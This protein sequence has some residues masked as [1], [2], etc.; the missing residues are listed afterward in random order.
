M[1]IKNKQL[2]S[3][4]DFCK[5]KYNVQ[6][7]NEQTNS[8]LTDQILK[9][10]NCTNCYYG[11]PGDGIYNHVQDYICVNNESEYVTQFVFQNMY[12]QFWIER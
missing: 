7:I 5:N 2:I 3:F 11:Q 8:K 4:I 9:E 1:L 12:C 10:S 6:F